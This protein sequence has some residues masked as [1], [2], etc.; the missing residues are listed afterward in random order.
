MRASWGQVLHLMQAAAVFRYFS[1]E[2]NL[3]AV[4][5]R[6][7]KGILVD[8]LVHQASWDRQGLRGAMRRRRQ[9]FSSGG[10]CCAHCALLCMPRNC[11]HSNTSTLH[12]TQ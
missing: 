12:G 9:H 11:Q 2:G 1:R 4:Y 8:G 10:A 6:Q 5:L 7:R 3:H